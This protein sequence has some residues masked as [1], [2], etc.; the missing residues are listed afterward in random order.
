[1]L[2]LGMFGLQWQAAAVGLQRLLLDLLV[3]TSVRHGSAVRGAHNV[4]IISLIQGIQGLARR[5]VWLYT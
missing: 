5:N 3:R 1:M 4:V 2:L